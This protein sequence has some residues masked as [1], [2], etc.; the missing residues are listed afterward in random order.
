MGLVRDRL[1]TLSIDAQSPDGTINVSLSRAGGIKVALGQRIADQHTEESFEE[2]LEEALMA[3]LAGYEEATE[4]IRSEA[5]GGNPPADAASPFGK[6]RDAVKTA[7]EELQVKVTSPRGFVA[8]EWVG[9]DDI[10]VA[11]RAGTLHKL[12]NEALTQEINS[13]IKMLGR[14]RAI[15]AM[16]IHKQVYQYDRFAKRKD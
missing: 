6:R 3:V 5:R 1:A 16:S 13:T 9:R 7:V 14:E 4:L 10:V 15:K 2:Q 12:D 11:L 8:I